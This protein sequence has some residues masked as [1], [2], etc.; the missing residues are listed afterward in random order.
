[1]LWERSLRNVDGIVLCGWRNK[2]ELHE[3]R[4]GQIQ[5]GCADGNGPMYTDTFRDENRHD[6][7][8]AR[9]LVGCKNDGYLNELQQS[10]VKTSAQRV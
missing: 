1:M 5:Q 8:K 10:V 7:S 2:F 6:A 9:H 4:C 3:G